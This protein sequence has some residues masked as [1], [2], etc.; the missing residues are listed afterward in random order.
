MKAFKLRDKLSQTISVTTLSSSVDADVTHVYIKDG[1]MTGRTRVLGQ[2]FHVKAL[3]H[4]TC[5]REYKLNK[6]ES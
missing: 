5:W 1:I 4:S 6:K 2:V 3:E